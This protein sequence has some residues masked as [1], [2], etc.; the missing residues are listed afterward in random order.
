LAEADGGAV[1]LPRR[2]DPGAPRLV[3]AAPRAARPGAESLA[4]VLPQT[5]SARRG[6]RAARR[7]ARLFDA[8]GAHPARRAP[9]D[10]AHRRAVHCPALWRARRQAGDGAPYAPGA[11]AR[12]R[13]RLALVF[14]LLLAAPPL[15]AQSYAARDEVKT[16]I[17][18]VV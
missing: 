3:A 10:P 13:V 11:R 9:A 4:H 5:W 6:A 1:H 7:A 12:A 18:E 8:R 14:F 15:F 2:D 16:F 17:D